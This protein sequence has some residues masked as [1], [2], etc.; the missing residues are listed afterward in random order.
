MSAVYTLLGDPVEHSVSPS[1]YEAAFQ[2]LAVDARYERRRVAAADLPR[3]LRKAATGGGGNVTLPHKL[4]AAS[5]L[6]APSAAVLGSGACNCFWLD[7]S[8][9]I[10]GDNTD[11]AGFLACARRLAEKTDAPL[12]GAHCLVLG[13][14]GAARAV[15]VALAEVGAGSVDVLNR[16]RETAE[17]LLA[18]VRVGR[19]A[20]RLLS[21]RGEAGSRYDLVV[22]ATSLGLRR[23]DPL[24]IQLSGLEIGIVLDCVYGR[25]GTEWTRHATSLGIPAEDGLEMLIEQ[26]RA[27]LLNWFG[28]S[29]D[30]RPLRRAALA[31]L[32]TSGK[33]S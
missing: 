8:A 30:A 6:D 2:S 5:L 4:S 14:G 15:L 24:P 3:A 10:A 20:V 9:S 7:A 13:A 33:S 23:G 31:A 17:R 16:S 19:L 25:G 18:E 28:A 29:V 26:A 1:L 11:V 27:S 12:N 21:D 32:R 22:N